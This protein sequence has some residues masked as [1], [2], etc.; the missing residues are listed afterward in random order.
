MPITR[1]LSDNDFT[2]ELAHVLELAFNATLRKL[3]LVDRNDP[4][5]VIVA[6]KVID[7]HKRGVRDAV[8]ISEMAARE[9]RVPKCG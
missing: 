3:Y 5:C 2:P 1:F 7:I 6:Q 8:A 9:L 4:I